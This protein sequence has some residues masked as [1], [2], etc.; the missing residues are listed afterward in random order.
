MP[1]LLQ[2]SDGT[3]GITRCGDEN[4]CGLFKTLIALN[5]VHLR[6]VLESEVPIDRTF[7]NAW[8]DNGRITTDM[9][10]ARNLHLDRIRSRRNSKLVESDMQLLRAIETDDTV[11]KSRLISLRQ[12]LRDLPQQLDLTTASTPDALKQIWPSE[13]A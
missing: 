13:L 3:L 8:R 11:E 6:D 4:N 10:I 7:R 9:V 1:H 5:A 2:L 12:T